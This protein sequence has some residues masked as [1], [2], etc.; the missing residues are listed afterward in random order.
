MP[1]FRAPIE[2]NVLVI[3]GTVFLLVTSLFTWYL[4]LPLYFRD[5]GASDAQVGLGYS[6]ITLGYT[7]MQFAGGLLTDR[8]GRKWLIVV[9]TFVFGPLYALAGAAQNWPTLLVALF[10]IN[11]LSAIQSPAFTSLLAESVPEDR[12]G[13]A[14]GAFEFAISLAIA[15]GPGLGALLLPRVGIRPLMYTTAVLSLVCA[16]LRMVGLRE[17]NHRPSPITLG[18]LQDFRQEQVRWFLVVACLFATVYTLTLWGPF[19]SL[20]AEDALGLDKPQ[21]NGLFAIGGLAAMVASLLG[22]R[23]ADRY[24]G[25]N[26]LAA[27]CLAHV[28]TMA[29]WAIVGT[30][31][32]G[33]ALFAAS[34]AGLQMG[35]VAYST[36]LTQIATGRSRG[37]LVGLFGTITGLIAALAPTVGTYLRVHFGSAAPFWAAL[38]LGFAVSLLLGKVRAPRRAPPAPRRIYSI[39]HSTRSLDE[40]VGLLAAHGVQV[41]V[42]VRRFPHS[43]K[44][45]QF[46]RETLEETLPGQGIEYHWLG[47]LLGG[48]RDGGYEGY[49]AT[50]EFGRGLAELEEIAAGKQTAFMCAEKLF[51]RCHRRF[52]A[53]ALVERGWRVLHIIEPG[54]EPYE[55]KSRP[56]SGTPVLRFP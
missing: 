40:M 48:Y 9:P 3:A 49:L 7:L 11:S 12:R 26:I 28:G 16:L 56:E 10:L 1:R 54:R 13:G 50:E 46:N 8:Y 43:R 6:L 19:A 36:L 41:L 27:A 51:F 25:R 44:N 5:L 18:H 2:S 45:P 29:A 21:I 35:I 33:L 31:P 4:L 23:L 37:T 53:D 38:G 20:H 55:H 42:D 24:G 34:N 32:T 22:G 17:T 47:D 30:S 14:F 39:G 52:I 15:V